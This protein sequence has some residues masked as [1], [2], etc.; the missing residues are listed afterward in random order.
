MGLETELFIRQPIDPKPETLTQFFSLIQGIHQRVPLAPS[1]TNPFRFFLANG[2]SV[3][4]EVGG[5]GDLKSALFEIATPEC[6]SPRDVVLYEIANEQLV[7]EV[8]SDDHPSSR[9]SLIKANMDSQGHTLGQHESYDMRIARGSG[10]L[11]WWLGLALILP[12]VVL[13]RLLAMAWIGIIYSIC[14]W[15][16][17]VHRICR[18]APRRV[19][20]SEEETDSLERSIDPF[21]HVRSM[22][23]TACGLRFLHWP[24]VQLFLVLIR[25]IALRSHRR[26][27][28]A[29]LASRSILDG[30]G[31]VD[32]QGRYWISQRSAMANQ[33]IGFGSYGAARPI[34]RC[35]PMLRD[36]IAGPF[37]SF[38]RIRRL[39]APKQRIE[40]AIGDSG[41][42]AWSQHLRIGATVLMIDLVEQRELRAAPRLAR[43]I[44]AIGQIARDW[45]LVRSVAGVRNREYTALELQRWYL[46]RLKKHLES[47]SDVPS[48]AWDIIDKW[49]TSLNQLSVKF[50]DQDSIP[51][52]LI[53]RLDWISKLWLLLQLD[54]S[55][56]WPIRKK[57]DIRYHEMSDQG[58]HRKLVD[59]VELAPVVR[60]DEI[61]TAR[62]SPPLH[63]PAQR[64]GNLIREFSAGDCD[65]QVEW[66][67]ATY[68]VDGKSYRIVF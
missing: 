57:I 43:P 37:W 55:T 10:L 15:V 22:Q 53:G 58:Y 45:M 48:E 5:S 2:S 28:A 31:H 1:R 12:L 41:M 62:R 29:F 14:S 51:K 27:L 6:K 47:R 7:E 3:S 9:W 8:F 30:A 40:L 11:L 49:Q 33:M 26:D 44:E 36:L 35:D 46:N 16:R 17:G 63:A 25:L 50:S 13:Y 42:C 54:P 56:A 21:L 38:S 24:V 60:S 66:R 34:F 32:E 65:L 39:F 64:R 61:S 59:L 52:M 67:Q 23:W 18:V 19:P 4:L 20:G 68:C